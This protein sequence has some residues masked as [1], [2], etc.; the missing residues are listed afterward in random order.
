MSFYNKAQEIDQLVNQ[1]GKYASLSPLLED[2]ALR[3]YFFRNISDPVFMDLLKS[4]LNPDSI[5][6]DSEG[7]SYFWPPLD[8]LEKVS[9]KVKGDA[10]N[11]GEYGPKL[12]RIIGKIVNFSKRSK[13]INNY[14]IWWY[15]VKIINNLPCHLIKENLSLKTFKLWLNEWSG[16][17]VKANLAISDIAD[18]LMG[19][20]ISDETTREYAEMIIYLVTRIAPGKQKSSIRYRDDAVLVWD[21]YTVLEAFKKHHQAISKRSSLRVIYLLLDRLQAALEYKDSGSWT[22]IQ[23]TDNFYKIKASRIIRN[24]S[25]FGEIG[26]RKNQYLCEVLKYSADQLKNSNFNDKD[27]LALIFFQIEPDESIGEPFII[28]ANNKDQFVSRIKQNLP[29]NISWEKSDKYTEKLGH[30]F[31]NLFEDH[32]NIWAKSLSGHLSSYNSEDAHENLTIIL[33]DILVARCKASS[34]DGRKIITALISNKYRF[35]LFKRLSLL[36]INQDWTSYNDLLVTFFKAQQNVLQKHDWEVELQDL[37]TD[38]SR[39]IKDADFVQIL[40][41]RIADPPDYYIKKG[42]KS[43]AY[44][45]Y[46]WLSPLKEN[47][48]FSS[49]YALAMEKADIKDK[50]PYQPDRSDMEFQ[51]VTHQSPISDDSLSAMAITDLIKFISD[52]KGADEWGS[53]EGKPDRR[54]LLDSFQGAVK[55]NPSKYVDSIEDFKNAPYAYIHR[56]FCGIKEA[57][58]SGSDIDWSKVLVFALEYI[59]SGVFLDAALSNQGPDSGE[60]RYIWVVEAVADLIADGCRNDARAFS[61]DHLPAADKIFDAMVPLLNG[62]SNPDTQRDSLTYAL[63]T[64]LGRTIMAYVSY[65]LRVARVAKQPQ[66]NWG[67]NKYERFFSIGIEAFIW[68]GRYL[69]NMRYLDKEYSDKKIQLFSQLPASNSNW[70]RFMEGYLSGAT[71][72]EDL[73]YAMRHNYEKAIDQKVFEEQ[74]DNRLVQH[75]CIG[76]LRGYESLNEQNENQ[77]LSL[78]RRMLDHSDSE[79]TRD[80]WVEV[81]SFFWSFVR[82]RNK[83]DTG[84]DEESLTSKEQAR[85]KKFWG[86]TY[87]N[88]DMIS[89]K[90]GNQYGTFLGRLAELTVLLDKID[91][92]TEKWVLLSAANIYQYRESM[93]FIEYLAKFTDNESA[94]RLGKIFLKVLEKMTPTY[95]TEDILAIVKLIY[96]KGDRATADEI[97]NTYGKRGY[98]FLRDIWARNQPAEMRG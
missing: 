67:T 86:W 35:P 11:Y 10:T 30:I 94:Q 93:F 9:I 73:Y 88:S 75:I 44:W 79:K 49:A 48:N 41:G 89:L 78:F 68:F 21:T 18:D 87:D 80:R 23:L 5:E 50:K 64:T 22:D 47:T 37:L 57:W 84:N 4:Y 13:K 81:V 98:H 26:F 8:F 7:N 60:G 40:R 83:E 59:S 85:I 53:I 14:H 72:Y 24:R 70:R 97:C 27:A 51:E 45:Q 1:P 55:K 82:K 63:N 3:D 20:F 74:I 56:L 15:S 95:K 65:A 19:K 90:L 38:H 31:N 25:Q 91:A 28:T 16:S 58:N 69:P 29:R 96:E 6:F 39:D 54:G 62:E 61:P 33:R 32:S 52:F 42:E 76:Y 77:A 43:A 66:A 12:L 92:T 17:T 34:S 46:T 71:F 2:K 36:C